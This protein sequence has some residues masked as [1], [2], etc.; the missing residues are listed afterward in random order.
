MDRR[1]KVEI[2]TRETIK[3]SSPTPRNLRYKNLS[4]L[5]QLSFAMSTPMLLFYPFRCDKNNNIVHVIKEQSQNLKTS[6]S[7]TLTLF[8]PL[9]GELK[10]NSFIEC[11]DYGVEYI[12]AQVDCSMMELFQ[13]PENYL[14]ENLFPIDLNPVDKFTGAI[15]HVNFFNC[16]GLAIGV[17][18]SHKIADAA[19]LGTFLLAWASMASLSMEILPE[20]KCPHFVSNTVIPSAENSLILPSPPPSLTQTKCITKRFTLSS[21]K[22]DMLK[23][24]AATSTLQTPT[25]VEV[26]TALIWKCLI[27]AS[28]AK[29]KGKHKKSV[30]AQAVN[31]RR[32]LVPHLPQ[33]YIG[34][35]SGK[36]L[37]MAEKERAE[38]KDLVAH[39]REGIEK[40]SDNVWKRVDEIL[41]FA[42]EF[43]ELHSREDLDLYSFTSLCGF[44]FY[45]VDFGWGK[46]IWTVVTNLVLKN[47]VVMLDM[48]DRK[49]VEVWMSLS[50][51]DMP[52]FE[53]N[54]ELL[55]F[56]SVNPS[57]GFDDMEVPPLESCL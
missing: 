49:G 52:L 24:K 22:I 2:I 13:N 20:T 5:D 32:R 8:Y 11:N 39:L 44:P 38:L 26:V 27:S 46:P 41:D 45:D 28:Q 56:A 10:N 30:L 50:E 1:V 4:L 23:A 17:S 53:A 37:V 6:L 12:E 3:P 18:L 14:L 15:I 51:E 40:V 47:Y 35:L 43:A 34:N 31:L 55:E 19:S 9:A 33:N 25:R 54:G 57:L 7:K 42:K 48:K 36:F 21:C 16:G 29:S